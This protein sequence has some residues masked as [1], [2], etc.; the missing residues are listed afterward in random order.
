MTNRADER[1]NMAQTQIEKLLD[2]TSGQHGF[3][4]INH[5][6]YIKDDLEFLLKWHRGNVQDA[7]THLNDLDSDF[8]KGLYTKIDEGRGRKAEI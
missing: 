6:E 2:A 7:K 3:W 4:L 8:V 5:V 1:N